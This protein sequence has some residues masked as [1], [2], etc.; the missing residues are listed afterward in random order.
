MSG[1]GIIV[2]VKLPKEHGL[3]SR[4]GAG[5]LAL[6]LAAVAFL[7]GSA[8]VEPDGD[9][10]VVH[11]AAA[12]PTTT[13]STTTTTVPEAPHE[14]KPLTHLASPKGV[15]TAYE[16]PGGAPMGDVGLWYGYEMTMPIVE[17]RGDWLRIMMPERPNMLTAWVKADEVV[18]STTTWHMVVEL[19]EFKL[20]VYNNG[21]EQFTAH[22]GIGR[23]HT[24]TPTGEYFAAV[25]E[26]PGPSGYGPVV[27]NLNAHSED[28][29]SWQG[30]GDAIT[31]FHGPFGSQSLIRSGGGKV[32]NGCLRM[33]TEDQLKLAPIPEGTPVDILP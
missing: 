31:A 26:K 27:V 13:T 9:S 29:E 22:L 19:S 18:R 32:S 7:A 17:E 23:D 30:T 28:I 1:Y 16:S 4:L 8:L 11:R 3:A 5:V 15:I 14:I 33:L 21:V 12:T 20:Y 24:R 25:V 10:R 2:D 6:S